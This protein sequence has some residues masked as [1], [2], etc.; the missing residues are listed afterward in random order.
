[1]K[2][3]ER[4]FGKLPS[5]LDARLFTFEN[6]NGLIISITNYGGIITSLKTPGKDGVSEEIC[7]GFSSL[8]DYLKDHPHFGVIVGRFANRIAK[9]QFTI[10]GTT[11]NLPINN[12]PNHLHGG[13]RGFHT[14]LWDYKIGKEDN[15]ARLI[16]THVSPHMDEGYPGN[17]EVTVTYT[18]HNNNQ[19]DIDFNAT[20]DAPTHVNLTSHGYFNLD[21]FKNDIA[22][23]LLMVDAAS[24]LE[25]DNTQ[26]PTGILAP[27][28]GTPFDF[29][30]P[31][32]LQKS[33]ESLKDGIDHCFVLSEP[34][35]MDKPA[36][37]LSS[38]K[39]GRILSVFCTH[40]G[41]QVYTSNWLDGTLVGHKETAY[42]R[43]SAIC[44]EMQHFPDT[45]NKPAFPSTLITPSEEYN[46][47]ATFKFD[48]VKER[49]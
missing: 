43:H 9:G 1:M 12:G 47:K 46:Q 15:L 35:T 17:L 39:G 19:L 25:V 3:Y 28:S 27:V 23:H 24:Y 7:A 48:I 41:L 38:N 20:T 21:G 33:L 36:T 40:P 22:N 4:I 49:N 2:I 45:P 6:T 8:D 18:I 44:L 37:I 11:Y 30:K 34:R 31:T 10:N 26:I 13:N 16:L 14:K 42:Q 5:G 29:S 32:H